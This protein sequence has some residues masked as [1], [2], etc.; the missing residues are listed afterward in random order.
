MPQREPPQLTHGERIRRALAVKR[1]RGE[2]VG[3]VP[4]GWQLAS[5]GR[6]LEP[7]D[8]ERAL[9]A[10]VR[11]MQLLEHVPVRRIAQIL[12]AEGVVTRTGARMS[13]SC[14]HYLLL[15]NFEED[16]QQDGEWNIP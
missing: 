15:K 6:T 3:T 11:H 7:H 2:R 9:A 16:E 5:D 10:R 14:V 4:L 1:L 13:R 12:A 8:G